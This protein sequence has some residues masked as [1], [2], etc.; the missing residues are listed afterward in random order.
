M[1]WQDIAL[2]FE[3]N[4]FCEHSLEGAIL[5]PVET[6]L[7]AAAALSPARSRL[8]EPPVR[9]SRTPPP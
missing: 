3:A 5:R 1:K 2:R 9:R 4:D 6:D 8:A 7:P